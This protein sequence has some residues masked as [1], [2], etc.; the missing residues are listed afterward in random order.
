MLAKPLYQ[1]SPLR[2][3]YFALSLPPSTFPVPLHLLINF[4]AFSFCYYAFL[5][6]P[7]PAPSI[8]RVQRGA[9]ERLLLEAM[10]GAPAGQGRQVSCIP[11]LSVKHAQSCQLTSDWFLT[12]WRVL[13]RFF[14]VM[15]AGSGQAGGSAHPAESGALHPAGSLLQPICQNQG[16]V[17]A[18]AG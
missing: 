3:L 12:I 7:L 4:P 13:V 10:V 9:V 18:R 16:A 2:G 17:K 8:L 6:L 11:A 1:L 5:L 14:P 15:R